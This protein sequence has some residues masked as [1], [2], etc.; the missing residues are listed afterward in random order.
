MQKWLNFK[1]L[2][3]L[4]LAVFVISF[5]APVAMAQDDAEGD[6][7]TDAAGTTEDADHSEDNGGGISALGINTGFL[8]A[9]IVNFML[10]FLLLRAILWKPILK[11]LDKRSDEIAKGLEDAAAAA[12]ARAN[13]ETEADKILAQARTEAAQVVEEASTRGEEVAKSIE[14]DARADA[15]KIRAEARTSAEA[16]RNAELAGLRDQVAAISMA[17]SNR[18]IGE[19]MDA[20]KQK[21]LITDFFTNIPADAKSLSGSIEI[22]SAMPLDEKEQAK[23]KKELGADDVSFSV[24]PSILGGLLVRAGDN[25]VDG[26]VRNQLSALEARLN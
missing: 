6:H 7:A 14:A 21:A 11:L 17:I 8:L 3:I 24:D 18:L 23:V 12:N 19:S 5:A 26:T 20:K 2:T 22:I 25:V 10:I 15:E 13:A 16:E 1:T 4:L 9:Q